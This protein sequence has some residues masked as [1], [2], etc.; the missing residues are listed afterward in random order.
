[1]TIARSAVDVALVALQRRR[2]D[3]RRVLS[4]YPPDATDQAARR[5]IL[6]ELAELDHA[7]AALAAELERLKTTPTP[8]EEVKHMTKAELIEALSQAP[9]DAVIKVELLDSD[10]GTGSGDTILLDIDEET[11]GWRQSAQCYV[12]GATGAQ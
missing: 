6:A 2:A 3:R 5:R 10:D 4:S 7:H 9:D 1:M 8:R 12:I 11:G